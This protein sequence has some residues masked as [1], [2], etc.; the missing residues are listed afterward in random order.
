MQNNW[1]IAQTQKLFSLAFIASE[2]GRGL[3]WA[4]NKMSNDCGR[5]INS[6]RNYYYS[7]LKMFQLVPSLASDL[8]I[9]LVNSNREQFE[10]FDEQ[11][12]TSLVKK[13]LV[14]K[15]NGQSVRAT[16]AN[17]S[18]GD[19]KL[20]L[21]L[22]NKYRS[23]VT[24]H[25]SKVQAIMGEMASSGTVFYNPYTKLLVTEEPQNNHKKLAEY[26]GTLNNDEVDNFLNIMQ[27][28]FA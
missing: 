23:M 4:F 13:I 25:K 21:R 7:Q 8:N 19:T 26:I 24:H 2:K 22:Q 10:L 5:S 9:K 17:L 18:N 6:V 28:L 16:I 27:K 15:A 1:S 11:E 14:A 3:N 12:I 20:A